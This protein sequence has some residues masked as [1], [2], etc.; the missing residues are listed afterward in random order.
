MTTWQKLP[1]GDFRDRLAIYDDDAL[2]DERPS[3]AGSVRGL[4]SVGFLWAAVLRR[5]RFLVIFTLAGLILG[6]GYAVAKPP[7]HTAVTTILLVDNPQE[8]PAYEILTDIAL[9]E[10]TP[11]ATAVVNQLGLRQTPASFLGTYSVTQVTTQVLSI[12]AKGPSDSVAIQRASAIATQYLAYRAKYSQAAQQETDAEL[13]QQVSQAQQ[14]LDSISGKLAAAQSQPSSPSQQAEVASLRQQQTDASNNLDTVKQYATTTRASTRTTTQ[15]MIQGSEVVSPATPGKRSIVKTAA[16]G[17]IGGTLGGLAIGAV[18]II[19]G[20]ITSDRLRRRD[21]IAY[22]FSAPVGLSVGPLRSGRLPESR[23]RKGL[24]ERDSERVVRHLRRAVPGRSRDAAALAVIA[25]D[26]VPT[27]AQA[28]VALATS[29]SKQRLRVVLADLSAGALAARQLGVSTPGIS[30]VTPAGAPVLVVVP[31][32]GD[33]API[34]PLRTG[35]SSDGRAPTTERLADA[36]AAAD[37]ILSLVTLD[38]AFGG[39]HLGTWAANAVAVVTAGQSTATR[40]RAVSE[41]IRLAG[42]H[43]DSVVVVD[44]D[45]SDESLGVLS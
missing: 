18:I 4:V 44:A 6:C 45:R 34:G 24:R 23:G 9:A 32:A 16:L 13:Q 17:V 15:Q 12:T 14:S 29:S 1:G 3:G 5:L 36:C 7:A 19:I 11:V 43:L 37:L 28:V 2:F 31:D 33:I 20:A 10:S 42:T 30:T 21:D 39:D 35:P 22:A 27:V 40:I 8:N 38:P 41:M 26:D 25:L